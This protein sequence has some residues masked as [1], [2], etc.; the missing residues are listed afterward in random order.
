[1]IHPIFTKLLTGLFGL[2]FCATTFA[3]PSIDALT[4]CLA[5]STT[6]KDRV[7]LAK[8][9]FVAISAH[10][11][12]GKIANISTSNIEEINKVNADL[13]TRLLVTDC[14]EETK[15]A[16]KL[17]NTAALRSAFESLGRLAMIELMGNQNVAN[18]FTTGIEKYTDKE[19][20]KKAFE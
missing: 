3:G 2:L 14:N 5:N 18:G 11:D 9:I 12:V 4:S 15:L 19:K 6:G 20:L 16:M 8:L 10:P 17:E 1:M 13:F 7:N